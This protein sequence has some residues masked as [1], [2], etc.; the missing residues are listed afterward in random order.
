MPAAL[1]PAVGPNSPGPVLPP[2]PQVAAPDTI[3]VAATVPAGQAA[4]PG[5]CRG[6]RLSPFAGFNAAADGQPV[7]SA[8]PGRAV[9]RLQATAL[10]PAGLYG[11]GFRG[12]LVFPNTGM[13]DR[14]PTIPGP[15]EQPFP[16]LVGSGSDAPAPAAQQGDGQGRLVAGADEDGSG[17][18]PEET[19]PTVDGVASTA[20]PDRGRG[21]GA[22][23]AEGRLG[24]RGSLRAVGRYSPS[25]TGW[26]CHSSWTSGQGLFRW[27]CSRPPAPPIP[28]G[29]SGAPP[30]FRG[31]PG[32]A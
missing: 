27:T 20:D 15:M 12:R 6:T 25:W 3:A 4:S 2:Q 29:Y 31:C 30:G 5:R 19:D 9:D 14:S 7:L 1:T 22:K 10:P 24:P 32:S 18:G 17:Q 16:F 23:R 21:S 11:A 8:A 13:Q 26:A 28:A